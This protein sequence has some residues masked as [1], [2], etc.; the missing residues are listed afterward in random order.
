MDLE[1]WAH[2]EGSGRQCYVIKGE[3]ASFGDSGA[4]VSTVDGVV[5]GVVWGRTPQSSSGTAMTFF[6]AIYDLLSI[7]GINDFS[8]VEFI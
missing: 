4:L 3:F 6:T 1:K 5:L 7:F 2:V 8:D